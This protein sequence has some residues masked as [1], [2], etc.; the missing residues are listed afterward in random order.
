MNVYF[1]SGLGADRR[2]FDKIK[3]DTHHIV[4]HIDWLEPELNES[5]QHYAKRMS[6][7]IDATQ[8]FALVGLSFG[9]IMSIEIDKLINAKKIILISSV[10]HRKEL[11]WYFKLSSVLRVH[12]L[13]FA[14]S[15]KHNERLMFWF[16]GTQ[17]NKLKAY[18][19]EMIDGVS[20]YYLKW[21]MHQIVN[22]KQ[23]HKPPNVFHIHG[24][25][26][27]IFPIGNIQADKIIVKGSHFM[28][29]THGK[30]ISEEIN[31]SLEKENFNEH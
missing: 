21:S 8:P 19:K 25:L 10:S 16:F 27:K 15:I 22:W 6:Q 23:E 30:Q 18:L 9:G 28:V 3:L 20:E 1:I 11:P 13:G 14:H 5:I 24:T 31:A 17:S 29:V 12:K 7:N 26:D 2:A 4:H